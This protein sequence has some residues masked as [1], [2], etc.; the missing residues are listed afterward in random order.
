M[1]LNIDFGIKNER[2]NSKIG[3]ACVGGYALERG[4]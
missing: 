1:H 4:G 3:T 2:W